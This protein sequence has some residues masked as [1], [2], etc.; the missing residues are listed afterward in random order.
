M[1]E[2]TTAEDAIRQAESFLNRYYAFR[3]LAGVRK[4]GDNWVVRFDVSIIGPKSIVTIKLD[5]K[6]GAVVEYISPE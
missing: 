3:R 1:K 6:T 2:I 4:E 5:S